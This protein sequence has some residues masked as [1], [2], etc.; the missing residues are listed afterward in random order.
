MIGKDTFKQMIARLGEAF[1]YTYT[2]VQQQTLYEEIQA[3]W[4][5]Y[6]PFHLDTA[7][8]YLINTKPPKFPPSNQE[9]IHA[10]QEASNAEWEKKK[11]KER[12]EA[13]EVLHTEKKARTPHAKEALALIKQIFSTDM[14]RTEILDRMGD[15]GKKYPHYGWGEQQHLLE[16]FFNQHPR[17]VTQREARTPQY[18]E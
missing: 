9:V 4:R 17:T 11:D 12:Q 10:I 2:S 15:M 3:S 16:I 1:G 13:N 8:R 6:A 7:I 14:S 18:A 5:N